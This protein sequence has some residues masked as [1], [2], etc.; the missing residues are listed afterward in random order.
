[1]KTTLAVVVCVL[2]A[3]VHLLAQT[4]EIGAPP[5]RMVD[6]GGRQFHVNCT[7]SGSPTVILEA[8]ASSFAID[9][10][11]VQPAI[12]KTN[13]VCSYDRAGMGWSAPRA[14]VDTPTRVISDL[15]AL[16]AAIGEKPPFVMVGASFGAL[17]VRFY[18]VEHPGEVAGLVLVDPATEDRLF[19]MFEGKMVTIGSLT[20]DQLLKT[21]PASGSVPNR[22][23]ARPPQTGAPFDRLPRDLYETRVKLDQRLIASQGASVSAEVVRESAEG[24]RAMFARLLESRISK[25]PPMRNTPT[26]VLTRGIEMTPGIAENH[27]GLAALSTNSRH[28]VVPDAGHEIH[29]FAPTVVIQAIQDVIA[30][31]QTKGR[32]ALSH[33]LLNAVDHLV[34]ATPDLQLGIDR[35]EKLLGVRATPGGL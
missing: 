19:T 10:T 8:G 2:V 7:G 16:L 35:I 11:L 17:Y 15:H 9:W 14:Q 21:L 34:Y 20:V 28:T 26:V 5:G 31:V 6:V 24:N 1:M 18:Q 3:T 12:S 23:G 27:A 25:D 4:I 29:L 33:D 32:L 30:A 13:R 22:A